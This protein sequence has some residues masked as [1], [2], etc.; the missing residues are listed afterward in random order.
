MSESRG[1]KLSPRSLKLIKLWRAGTP[2]DVIVRECDYST[3]HVMQATVQSLRKRGYDMPA[4]PHSH[5]A[6]IKKGSAEDFFLRCNVPPA[7]VMD[8][9]GKAIAIMDPVTRMRRPITITT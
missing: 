3:R 4:R 2:S 5:H 6:G 9:S 1:R 7:V 8:A